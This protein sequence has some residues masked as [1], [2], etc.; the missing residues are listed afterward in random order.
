MARVRLM[1]A[2]GDYTRLGVSPGTVETWED[3]RRTEPRAGVYEWWY[4]DAIADDGTK[5]VIHFDTKSIDVLQ[6]PVDHP[7][8]TV[9]LTLADGTDVQAKYEVGPDEATY[10]SENCETR[11][12]PHSFVGDLNDYRIHV[13]PSDGIGADLTLTSHA[14]SY[15]PGTGYIGFGDADEQ[16]FTWLCVV[17]RG[18]VTGTLTYQGKTVEVHGTGYHDH[19]WSD[20]NP[21]FAWNNWLWARQSFGDYSILVFDFVAGGAFDFTRFPIAFIHDA[22]GKLVFDNTSPAG[23]EILEEYLDESSGKDY[24]K[25]S[26]YTFRND[27]TTVQYRIVVDQILENWNYYG[28]APEPAK[29]MFDQMGKKPTYARYTANG[30]LTIDDGQSK[31]ERSGNLIYEFVY[32]GTS[33]KDHVLPYAG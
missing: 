24:P 22:D 11:F 17:P 30:E 29:A 9:K 13:E 18:E 2:P 5:I 19:Q 7:S 32:S 8:V 15:R 14:E 20:I 10:G 31:V 4:F 26:R 27:D 21:L 25:D 6:D 16:F 1:N 28:A 23:Y 3:G 12:G 33:Y